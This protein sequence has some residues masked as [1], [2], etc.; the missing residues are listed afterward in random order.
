MSAT[1]ASPPG[2]LEE[3]VAARRDSLSAAERK[4]ARYLADH[5]DK[6]AFASAAELGQLT[7]TSDATV[8]R[9]IKSLGYDGL[10]GLKDSLRENIR[11]RLTPA[12]R[13]SHSLDAMGS[14]PDSLLNQV[15]TASAQLLDEA[16]RTIRPESF[17][18]AVKLIG[19]ARETL[20]LGPGALGTFCDYL[21]LRLNRLRHRARSTAESGAQLADDL[22]PLTS[23][24]VLVI[25]VYKWFSHDI[26]VALDYAAK[27]G[28]KVVLVTDTLGE[29]LADRVTVSISAPAGDTSAFRIQANTLAI[30][31]ALAL[32]IAAQDREAALASM[33][34]LDQLRTSLRGETP[35]ASGRSTGTRRRRPPADGEGA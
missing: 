31:E 1:D 15:L 5:P 21:A 34:E 17:A 19:T 22:F 16:K 24:D 18:D 26:E 12:G 9:T 13:M 28:A 27:V 2:T 29:A 10:P 3:R 4:V 35:P 8:I 33:T 20:V 7:G 11:E 23:E 6:V 32:A 25:V 14:E 30:L